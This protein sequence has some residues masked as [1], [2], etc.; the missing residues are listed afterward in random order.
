[1][2]FA[3]VLF[4]GLFMSHNPRV[5]K[6]AEEQY[7][8][9]YRWEYVGKQSQEMSFHLLPLNLSREMKLSYYRLT[10]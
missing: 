4:T 5:F 8:D 7:N 2:G 3:L 10:K 6:T 1:M 9:G